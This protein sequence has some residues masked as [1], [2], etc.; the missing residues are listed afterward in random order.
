MRSRERPDGPGA[1]ELVPP[2]LSH[3]ATN[4]APA[5]AAARRRGRGAGRSVGSA[6]AG[7]LI[8]LYPSFKAVFNVCASVTAKEDCV[9]SVAGP[10]STSRS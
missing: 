7:I 3:T 2:E 1:A 6:R 9:A 8:G 5:A 10:G 4:A